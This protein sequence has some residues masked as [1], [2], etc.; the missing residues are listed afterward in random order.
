MTELPQHPH[1]KCPPQQQ[2]PGGIREK[3][4]GSRG[5]GGAE[6]V[7]GGGGARSECER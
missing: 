5:E 6:V 2:R 4:D 3:E 7:K 1:P